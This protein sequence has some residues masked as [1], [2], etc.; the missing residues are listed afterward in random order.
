MTSQLQM[1]KFM[2]SNQNYLVLLLVIIV[3]VT[4]GNLLS[5]WVGKQFAPEDKILKTSEINKLIEDE[6]TAET[7]SNIE[8]TEPELE[9][10]RIEPPAFEEQNDTA[11]TQTELIDQRRLDKD[12]IRLA[13][14]CE[15]WKQADEDM[16]TTTSKR[17]VNKH[18]GDYEL[19]L[20]TGV[21]TPKY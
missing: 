8:S 1:G 11:L 20:E 5:A 19:Y 17:G 13:K 6:A 15:E 12:G 7:E 16:H 21:V 18:C 14:T 4:S 10:E 2:Q 9:T 3:G